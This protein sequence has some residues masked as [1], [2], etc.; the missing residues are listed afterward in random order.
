MLDL[1][2]L[3]SSRQLQ[4]K[5]SAN[6]CGARAIALSLRTTTPTRPAPFPHM[7]ATQR[8]CDE[9]FATPPASPH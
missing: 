3:N 2:A 5:R 1:D 4:P 7:P 6:L 9:A 8:M